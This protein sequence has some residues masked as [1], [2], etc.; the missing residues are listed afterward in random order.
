MK[1]NITFGTSLRE[2]Q[3]KALDNI[4]SEKQV[5]RSIVLRW[6]VDFYLKSLF[7]SVCNLE[8]TIVIQEDQNTDSVAI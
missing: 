1:R 2:D 5:S 6:A 8:E 4:A 3:L 7:L